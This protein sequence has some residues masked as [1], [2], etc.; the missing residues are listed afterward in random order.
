MIQSSKNLKSM[1]MGPHAVRTRSIVG[2][3]HAPAVATHGK[4]Y[5]EC[6]KDN[7]FKAVLAQTAGE[8]TD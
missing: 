7:H 4:K 6:S 3:E 1:H 2:Q 5:G 8:Q